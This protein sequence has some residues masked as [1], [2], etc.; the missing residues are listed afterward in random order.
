MAR[1]GDMQ[2]AIGRLRGGQAEVVREFLAG[3]VS[4]RRALPPEG[5]ACEETD[6]EAFYPEKGDSSRGAKQICAV[7]D[8]RSACLEYALTHDEQFGIWGGMSTRDRDTF[9]A[10]RARR[11]ES[12]AAA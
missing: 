7:C 9:R 6:P 12:Q 4:A 2:A 10:E 5:G 3:L 8:I 1:K 11:I